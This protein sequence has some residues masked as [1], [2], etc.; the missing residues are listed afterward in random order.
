[1]TSDL[2]RPPLGP[3][4]PD[5]APTNGAGP[6]D[7]HPDREA[8]SLGSPGTGHRDD[9]DYRRLARQD[10]RARLGRLNRRLR[11][12]VEAQRQEAAGLD[13]P[14][15][16]HLAITDRHAGLMMERVERMADSGLGDGPVLNGHAIGVAVTPAADEAR[17]RGWR[18]PIERLADVHRLDAIDELA[19]LACA[20]PEVDAGYQRLYAY[21]LD[22][23]KR[24]S[25]C[26]ALIA[27]LATVPGGDPLELRPRLGPYGR[28]RSAG[29]LIGGVTATTDLLQDLRLAPGLL[30]LLLGAP[31]DLD[32]IG[33][34]SAA[35]P[36]TRPGPRPC[37]ESD[38]DLTGVCRS[39]IDR[40]GGALGDGRLDVAGIWG[41]DGNTRDHVVSALLRRTG[42]PWDRVDLGGRGATGSDLTAALHAA[43]LGGAVL[44]LALDD[45]PPVPAQPAGGSTGP[46]VLDLAGADLIL[47]GS[48]VPVVICGPPAAPR[49]RAVMRRRAYAEVTVRPPSTGDRSELWRR[50]VPGADPGAVTELAGRFRLTAGDIEAAASIATTANRLRPEP[51]ADPP[52]LDELVAAV[53]TVARVSSGTFTTAVTPRRRLDELV[54][55]EAEHTQVVEIGRFHRAWPSVTERWGFGARAGRGV[56]ALFVGEPGT[57]KT[58][59]AEVIAGELGVDL[60]KV[61]LAQ[62]VSKWVGET[63]KNLEAAFSEA[64]ATDC[65]LFFDEADSLFGKRGE[66]R[67]GTDRYANLEVGY[68]LQ[69]LEG[70]EGLVVLAS[71]L[72]EN[73]DAAFS[74][75]FH[76][77]IHFPRPDEEQRR[78]LW[79]LAFPPEAPVADLDADAL[80][81]LDL[82]GAGIASTAQSAALLA[83]AEGAATIGPGHVALA[84]QRQFKREGRALRA[85]E[86]GRY[87]DLIDGAGR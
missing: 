82:T 35:D 84:L 66:V 58:M 81:R 8:P 59:A 24:T 43:A 33:G 39:Q 34:A 49:P 57:G 41:A 12:I 3:D 37:V 48:D 64:E 68:L 13:R 40:L 27:G 47:A 31:V 16:T 29:L 17:R 76:F 7:A 56:K 86:L 87:A 21:A 80:A 67:H 18:L 9:P 72:S 20:A 1:M 85:G 78:R 79:A 71:N 36:G 25:A 73:I 52:G 5:V 62:V 55:P 60:V 53:P 83:A 30:E 2:T 10:L 23:L 6:N 26:P 54:L 28:L 15:V 61:D 65:V 69:R 63:E 74:R 45:R 38:D 42:R 22:D 32:L 46:R 70:Y 51:I 44:W 50:A 19:V 77:V 11:A 14:D 75:R 4:P